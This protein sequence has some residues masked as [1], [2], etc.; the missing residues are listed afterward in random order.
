MENDLISRE[1]LL[2]ELNDELEWEKAQSAPMT[3]TAAFKI[4]IRRVKKILAVDAVK[5]VRC[6]DCRHRDP[7]DK[8]CD[9]GWM[10]FSFPRPDYGY[11]EHG[12]R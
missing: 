3:A 10:Y 12:E 1:T 5:V 6:K 8:R 4:A 11:C 7:D 2:D 9:H